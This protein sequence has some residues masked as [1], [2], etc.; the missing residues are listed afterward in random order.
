MPAASP[1]ASARWEGAASC[2]FPL[3]AAGTGVEIDPGFRH[4]RLG[5]FDLAEQQRRI[6]ELRAGAALDRLGEQPGRRGT[7]DAPQ[8]HVG[9]VV[10]TDLR[11]VVREPARAHREGAFLLA[12]RLLA[13]FRERLLDETVNEAVD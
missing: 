2:K 8:D 1:T 13:L 7:L 12:E 10:L 9:P 5:V 4:R 11:V 6:A 3:S